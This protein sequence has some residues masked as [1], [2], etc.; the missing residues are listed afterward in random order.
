MASGSAQ[1]RLKRH[2]QARA[3]RGLC[4]ARA[5]GGVFAPGAPGTALRLPVRWGRDFWWGHWAHPAALWSKCR[6]QRLG[7]RHAGRRTWLA[8][9]AVNSALPWLR[10]RNV[11]QIQLREILPYD[12]LEF[13]STYKFDII[14]ILYDQ[15]VE[16]SIQRGRLSYGK[17]TDSW[18]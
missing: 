18:F 13:I 6:P 14:R 2:W 10:A 8:A 9:R 11:C 16:G 3:P 15:W 4:A 12:F 5:A 7:G 1:L 17:E